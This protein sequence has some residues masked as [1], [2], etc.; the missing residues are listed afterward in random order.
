VRD[1]RFPRHFRVPSNIVK[2]DDKTDPNLWLEDYRLA[3][4]ASKANNDLLIV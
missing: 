2:Y 4:R 1:T 3:C